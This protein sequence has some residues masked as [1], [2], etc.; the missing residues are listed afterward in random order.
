MKLLVREMSKGAFALFAAGCIDIVCAGAL[1]AAYKL[2]YAAKVCDFE[3]LNA[4]GRQVFIAVP[5]YYNIKNL[6]ENG[7]GAT[8]HYESNL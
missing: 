4:T 5:R 6:E 2:L 8:I 1:K 7:S 3:A